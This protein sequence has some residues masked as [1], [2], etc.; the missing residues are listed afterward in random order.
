MRLYAECI[1]L[2]FTHSTGSADFPSIRNSSK[3]VTSE[4][5]IKL[6]AGVD[7]G[8]VRLVVEDN[9]PGIS[10]EKRGNLFCKFQDSLDS[11]SQGT[12][13]GLFLCQRLA[14]LL[15]GDIYLDETYDSGVEGRPGARFVIDLNRPP[16]TQEAHELEENTATFENE[17]NRNCLLSSTPSP[18]L[19]GKLK[20]L[21]TDDDMIIRKLSSRM[22]RKVAPDWEI[23][24]ASCGETALKLAQTESFDL[25]K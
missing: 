23:T 8:N 6:S 11:L 1:N 21:F 25:S 14:T 4:G 7:N 10:P 18:S 16:H 5:V 20:V 13:V 22:I 24:E 17:S 9:G 3:F 12:G 15:D 19:P 2:S